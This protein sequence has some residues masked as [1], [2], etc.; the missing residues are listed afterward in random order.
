M[1][2]ELLH[3]AELFVQKEFEEKISQDFS[4]HNFEHT[5]KVKSAVEFLCRQGELSESEEEILI[6]AAL[7]H[8]LGF[9][10]SIDNHE[11]ASKDIA[12]SFLMGKEY[13]AEKIEKV[14]EIIEATR[15]NHSP[16]N[17]LEEIII[18]ADLSG[19]ANVHYQEDA[20]KLRQE[21]EKVNK[22]ILTDNEWDL[23][24]YNFMKDHVY[25]TEEAQQN[26][27]PQKNKNLAHLEKKILNGT[28]AQKKKK[29]TKKSA[30]L[31]RTISSNKSAQT[32]FKT[33]LRNHIDLSAI[34]DNKANIMLSVNALII[35]V[36]LPII[37]EKVVQ[38][39][40]LLVPTLILLVVCITS[41]IYATLAT[42]PIKMK[43]FV[44]QSAIK[45]KKSNLFF[46]GNFF[47]MSFD[48]YETGMLRVLKKPELLD[49][50]IT[51]DLFFL[52]KALGKKYSNLRLCYNIFMYGII[53]SVIAFIVAFVVSSGSGTTG[54]ESLFQI[55]G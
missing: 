36:A 2:Q 5:Q 38:N 26:Y 37:A 24:N 6:L 1:N 4:Y 20:K 50:A 53:I 23:T 51:R 17:K 30:E 11:E 28:E 42:R 10:K 31:G 35:T 49:N 40:A 12:K 55:Q 46:F 8:D 18:D 47:K 34:A 52:G 41:M 48:E 19:L 45:S 54:A 13:P 32:Q 14:L 25:Y 15:K 33:A 29:K 3:Q 44:D 27:G 9:S 22:Q 7:F 21:W 16:K 43:G 39:I